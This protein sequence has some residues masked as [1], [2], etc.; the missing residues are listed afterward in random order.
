MI[1]HITH[2]ASA[3]GPTYIGSRLVFPGETVAVDVPDSVQMVALPPEAAAAG[4]ALLKKPVSE[5]KPLLA[6]FDLDELNALLKLELAAPK[7]RT[8]LVTEIEE[9]ILSKT[10]NQEPPAE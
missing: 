1:K 8:T 2:P 9:V 5:I 6:D 3:K 10:V 4:A 7:P